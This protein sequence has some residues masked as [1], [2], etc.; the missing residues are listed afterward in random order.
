MDQMPGTISA[1]PDECHLILNV[2]LS[3]LQPKISTGV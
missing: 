2:N 3:Y 1:F